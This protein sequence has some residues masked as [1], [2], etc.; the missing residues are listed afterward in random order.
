MKLNELR[1]NWGSAQK[2]Y[3]KGRGIGSGNGKTAGRGHKGQKARSGGGVRWGFEG[4]QT[5]LF[6]QVPKR[7]FNHKAFAKEIVEIRLSQLNLFEDGETVNLQTVKEK[8]FVK[9][10]KSTDGIKIIGGGNLE[11]KLNVEAS[12]F[13]S[14]A[15]EA[16]EKAG[17]TVKEV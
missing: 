16:I 17:G 2:N 15:K 1:P 5:P 14:S 6:R 9:F 3:R 7:G 8:G 10:R 4:G 11:K 13:T 12:G